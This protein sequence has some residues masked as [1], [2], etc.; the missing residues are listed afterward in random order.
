MK[1]GVLIE[2]LALKKIRLPVSVFQA[3]CLVR[4]KAALMSLWEPFAS[5]FPPIIRLTDITHLLHMQNLFLEFLNMFLF[6]IT[7]Y[8]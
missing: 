2:Q 8:K 7:V 6:Y 4:D 3:Q 5:Q 1:K